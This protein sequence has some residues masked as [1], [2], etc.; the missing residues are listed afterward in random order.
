MVAAVS[1]GS[2]QCRD[3]MLETTAVPGDR[4]RCSAWMLAYSD[5]LLCC[6]RRTRILLIFFFLSQSMCVCVCVCTFYSDDLLCCVRRTRIL[7]ISFFLSQSMCVCVRVWA[8]FLS[9]NGWGGMLLGRVVQQRSEAVAV[10][11]QCVCVCV[12][13]VLDPQISSDETGIVRGQGYQLMSIP[14][15][16]CSIVFVF[17]SSVVSGSMLSGPLLSRSLMAKC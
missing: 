10:L 11:S 2:S 16:L 14:Q 17:R 15:A 4:S 9:Q 3:Y 7:L 8:N 13:S 1:G 5:D 12:I 6:V